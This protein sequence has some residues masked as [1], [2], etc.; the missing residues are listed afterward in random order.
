MC[1]IPPPTHN[2]ECAFQHIIVISIVLHYVLHTLYVVYSLFRYCNVS[3]GTLHTSPIHRGDHTQR[4][5]ST[6]PMAA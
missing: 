5:W 3:Q 2:M 6:M 1:V 4:I